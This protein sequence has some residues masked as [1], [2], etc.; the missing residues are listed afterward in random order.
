[1][2]L[3]IFILLNLKNTYKHWLENIKDWCISRQLWWG[4]R[5]PAWYTPDGNIIIAK[6]AE[7]AL[8]QLGNKQ[9]TINDLKQDEDVLDTWFSSWLWPISVFDGFQK[10]KHQEIDYYYPTSDLVTAPDIIFFWVA[11]MIMAGH[12]FKGQFPFK[13]VYFTGIV[14]DKDRRKMSKSLGNSP[15]PIQLMEQFGTDGVRMGLM[16]SAPAGNDILFDEALCEQG[17]NFCNKLWN[18]FRFLKGLETTDTPN[19]YYQKYNNQIHQWMRARIA[20]STAIVN[21][22]FEEFRISDALMELYKLTRDDFSGWYLEMIKPNYG[23]PIPKGDLDQSILLF[24]QILKLLHPF[25]PFITEEIWHSLNQRGDE[26]INQ[27]SW[28]DFKTEEDPIHPRVFDL[29]TEIRSKRNENGISPKVA[30]LIHLNTNNPDIY[31]HSSGIIQKL[32]HA[33]IAEITSEDTIFKVLIG[34]DEVSLTFN[35][36]VKKIDNQSVIKEINRLK[37]FLVSIDKKLNNEKFMN[38]ANPSIIA[39]EMKKKSDTELKIK[40]LQ[41]Q[42]ESS[43]TI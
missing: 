40:S 20:K 43:E 18:S 33:S 38:N 14:R 42:I 36:F 9:W 35:N 3:L 11:R 21:T 25:M 24:D 15:D 27:Q 17:R 8:N 23:N 41:K 6:T 7:E 29:I 1:M 26:F 13:N 22:N 39:N 16:L 28:P 37:G 34:T 4:H 10:D 2:E 30:A 32:A 12:A 19:I 5:I 31:I